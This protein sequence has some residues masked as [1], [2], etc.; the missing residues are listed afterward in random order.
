MVWNLGLEQIF[1]SKR[2][3][4]SWLL[5]SFLGFGFLVKKAHGPPELK[6]SRSLLR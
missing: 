6:Q 5:T 3:S 4:Q 2:L 1:A